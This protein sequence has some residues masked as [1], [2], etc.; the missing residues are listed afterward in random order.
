MDIAGIF[1]PQG[2][3]GC[4]HK[5]QHLWR[6]LWPGVWTSRSGQLQGASTYHLHG[7]WP[8]APGPR[9]CALLG[10]WLRLLSRLGS[11]FLFYFLFLVVLG[12]HC[13]ARGLSLIAEWE[14][15]YL[16]CAGFSLRWL[17]LLLSMGSR[18]WAQQSWRTGL[19]ALRHVGSSRTRDRTRIPCIG[20]WFLNHW[21]TRN[22]LSCFYKPVFLISYL[23]WLLH[24]PLSLTDRLT[25]LKFTQLVS[26]G[27]RIPAQICLSGYSNH[28]ALE[29]FQANIARVWAEELHAETVDCECTDSDR[30]MIA[31]VHWVILSLLCTFCH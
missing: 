31:K 12:L 6:G 9:E 30:D 27:S 13:C 23:I 1:W 2:K 29:R 18:A 11:M 19:V 15:L 22:V 24:W 7:F 28:W 10:R 16:Q 14:L 8:E 20:K 17:L 21:T 4:W 5:I 26:G 3:R 25:L